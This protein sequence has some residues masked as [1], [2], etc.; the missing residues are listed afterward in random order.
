MT[1]NIDKT[2]VQGKGYLYRQS[3][4]DPRLDLEII[5]ERVAR[6]TDCISYIDNYNLHKTPS[7][8]TGVLAA[9]SVDCTTDQ[10]K[11][12]KLGIIVY[13]HP[14]VTI[15][16]N[17]YFD[18]ATSSYKFSDLVSL[19]PQDCNLSIRYLN[20][21]TDETVSSGDGCIECLTSGP[22]V[23]VKWKELPIDAKVSLDI[24]KKTTVDVF[25]INEEMRNFRKDKRRGLEKMSNIGS[26]LSFGGGRCARKNRVGLSAKMRRNIKFNNKKLK[27]AYED[28]F[29]F[30]FVKNRKGKQK[31]AIIGK[32]DARYIL[33]QGSL[34]V[35]EY[36]KL[37]EQ[38]ASTIQEMEE[39]TMDDDIDGLILECGDFDNEIP[40]VSYER[41]VIEPWEREGKVYSTW[42][43]DDSL[44]LNCIEM[45]EFMVMKSYDGFSFP[46]SC[47]DCFGTN[48]YGGPKA[49]NRVRKSPRMAMESTSKS[50][51]SRQDFDPTFIPLVYKLLNILSEKAVLF[52]TAADRVYDQFLLDTHELN[53]EVYNKLICRRM[54]VDSF[55]VKKRMI[56]KKTQRVKFKK[57]N[58]A[59]FKKC[60]TKSERDGNSTQ[61]RVKS[62]MQLRR[63]NAI[64]ILTCANE[65]IRGFANTAHLDKHD[66]LNRNL[67]KSA[68]FIINDVKNFIDGN[69][70]ESMCELK[71][72]LQ[73]IQRLGGPDSNFSTY[74][75]CGYKLVLKNSHL[76][77]A[78][79]HFLFNDLG[80]AIRIPSEFGCYHTFGG[81]FGKHQTSVPLTCDGERV[82]FN[83]QDLFVFAWGA[84]RSQKR[85]YLEENG[86]VYGNGE[87]FRQ[88]NM[89]DFFNYVADDAQREFITQMNW[90]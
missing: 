7:R 49:S 16:N 20:R 53:L 11:E 60:S 50:Q 31:F 6:D 27:K 3:A 48:V 33:K 32:K 24:V 41:S 87:R 30:P 52:Q 25:T 34:C 54:D 57:C 47:C 68:K 65:L 61:L 85:R 13:L 4:S 19:D 43:R 55:L 63:A 79:A 82:F 46:R 67:I 1:T 56:K 64:S 76:K 39:Y 83:D 74:T 72:A 38:K 9:W 36:H 21:I 59:K 37:L 26:F 90:V 2:K 73:H 10:S 86:V 66:C 70:S 29:A 22:D 14:Q 81:M 5:E 23:G 58:S 69:Q 78:Y 18:A 80:A 77:R 12:W 15:I 71:Q 35:D 8:C 45:L 89:L 40:E 28:G 51:Y 84:G 44:E 17:C 62:D 75:T 42:G 88:Q